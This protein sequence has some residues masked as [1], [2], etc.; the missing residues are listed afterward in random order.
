MEQSSVV[1]T[2]VR[3]KRKAITVASKNGINKGGWFAFPRP[4][5]E[6]PSFGRL[7][8]SQ[9][10]LWCPYCDE[11]TIFEKGKSIYSDSHVCTGVCGWANTNDFHV[12]TVNK[13]WFEDVP[14]S[15]LRKMSIPQ[16]SK[17]RR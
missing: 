14:L 6:P 5:E 16:P 3:V 8:Q 15:E 4:D 2:P 12:K 10:I 7:K 17:G 11:W 13:I 9:R 1:R